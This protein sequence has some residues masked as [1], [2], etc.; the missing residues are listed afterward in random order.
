[1]L[2]ETTVSA[3]TV[4]DAIAAACAQL[5]KQREDVQVE[6][7]EEPTF[8]LF[9]KQKTDAKVRVYYEE[10]E[11]PDKVGAAVAYV[12]N[13]LQ[14]MGLASF[15]IETE[16]T[17]GRL[18]L[19]VE[20]DGLGVIIGRRG[21]T[22]NALQY[23]T[24]LV[25][26]RMGGDYTRVSIDSGN[27]RDK[28]DQTLHQL[29]G[30]LARGVAKTGRSST[31]EPMNP[32]ER[33]VIHSVVSSMEGVT[34][35]SIGEEPN[36]RVVISSTNPRRDNRRPGDR[37]RNRSRGGQGGNRRNDRPYRKRD[38]DVELKSM[39][40]SKTGQTSF[41]AEYARRERPEEERK[42]KLYEKIDL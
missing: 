42:A 32:Y 4:D 28:R 11:A 22:L 21:E 40:L 33:R 2:I 18:T 30:K 15:E 8:G 20:G 1:M 24:S 19:N 26:N 27:Y 35:K 6:V 10:N 9:G 25:V 36:R 12:T 7:L 14:G 23:L 37:D 41:E 34:S 5:E 3:K 31:L 17:E 29:A 16:E 39:N 38:E 13:V